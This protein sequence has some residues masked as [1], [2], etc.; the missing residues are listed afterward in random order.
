MMSNEDGN[1]EL[2]GEP[3]H[4]GADTST[5]LL[6][7]IADL[8]RG[9][10]AY[11]T[12][13]P[14]VFGG[15]DIYNLDFRTPQARAGVLAAVLAG[16]V[17]ANRRPAV[18]EFVVVAPPGSNAEDWGAQAKRDMVDTFRLLAQRDLEPREEAWLRDHLRTIVAQ[19]RRSRSVLDLISAQPERAAIIVTDAASY[20]D[21]NIDPYVG[22]GASTPLLPEDV[23]APQLH[24]LGTAAVRIARERKLYVALDAN[25]LSPRR[26]AL[27]KLLCS[28]DGCGV[29]GSSREEDPETIL[30]G[31]VQEWDAWVHAGRLG[32]ALR[33]IEQLPSK[34]DGNKPYLRIQM[35][36]RA[37]HFPQALQA[38]RE[39]LA[40]G[41]KLDASMRVK[42]ARIAQD[43]NA[44]R[45]AS[46]ILAPAVG[47][48]ENREDLESALATAQQAG[49]ADLE[50]RM[51][52]RLAAM[53][54]GSPGLRQRRR[55]ALFTGRDYAAIA[56][57]AAEE[58]GGQGRV[59]FYSRLAK[60]LSG[61]DV[62]DYHALLASA[63]DDIAQIDA[64]RIACVSDALARSLVFHAF[65]LAMPI[66]K[67]PAEARRGERLLLDVLE[68]LLLL[69]DQRGALPV[70]LD[71]V[72]AALLSLIERL[73]AEP[74]N[75][76]LRI[77]LARLFQ[78]SVAGMMGLALIASLVL[79]LASRPIRL[80][81]WHA[82][83]EAD[84]KWLLERKQFLNA[85]FDWLKSEEPV[86]IG[87]A[88]IPEHLM[89]EPADEVVS[90]VAKYLT[91][92]PVESEED[93]TALQLWLTL[94]ASMTAHS[95]DTDFDLRLMRLLAGK[96]ASAGHAQLARDLAEQT[97]L[98]STATPRRRRLGW[99][100][101]ADV[102]HRCHD[103][104]EGLLALACTLAAD[105]AADEEQVWQEVTAVAR[106]LRDSGLH[107]QARSA[108]GKARQLLQRMGLSDLNSHR[109]DTLELQIRQT[110]IRIQGSDKAELE[111]LLAD[112]VRNGKAVLEHG[113]MTE[114]AA[115]MLGQVLLWARTKGAAITP[116]AELVLAELCKGA[117][118]SLVSL[119]RTMSTPEPSAD[120]LLA[121][122]KTSGFARYS[123]DVGYDMRN[124]AIAAS[125]ALS[126]AKYI[127]VGVNTS[128]ALETLADRGVAVPGWDEAAEPPPAPK[129]IDEP[130][131]IACS[132]SREGLSVVQ[133]GFD[134]LG[135]LVRVSAVDGRLSVPVRE[136]DDVMHEERLI[137]WAKKFPYAY[138]VDE[139][140]TNLFYTTTA[141]LRLSSLPEGPVVIVA[142]A[143]LQTF[144][145]NL[146]YV[147]EE[148]AGR[149]R[150]MAAAPSLA[151]LKAARAKGMIGDGRICAWISTTVDGA[152]TQ[153]LP[154]IAERLEP[155]FDQYRVIVDN[156]S[157]LP[158]EFAGA[159]MA[160]IA[161]HG[162][163]HPEGRF[164][165]VVSDE[166][167]LR[168]SAGELANALRNVGIV[169]LFVCS[170]GRADKHPWANTTLGL[171][172]Q[173]L[174][175]GCAA[176]IASPW[177]L[178]SRVPSHWL[179]EFLDQWS[180]GKNLIDANFAAN[181][182]VDQ[183]FSR[184]PARGLAMTIFGNPGLRRT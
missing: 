39:E 55:R 46:E 158:P 131:E 87:R 19:D 178:D 93:I 90:A 139:T 84:P 133:A 13:N 147:G 118:G 75:H 38:I 1:A 72:Q 82:P 98:N 83:G 62:P 137:R 175:R 94:A 124:L 33:D 173:I 23:W 128:F 166:G 25:Q 60:Y 27:S 48:L 151:W 106:F 61:P 5:A 108:I 168:V 142:D 80:E 111:A 76:E 121:L 126:S 165:R 30:A 114:P 130:A 74:S 63:G 184:D 99:F 112:V 66:P 180:R 145:P 56:A 21:D 164:F 40:S 105:D 49:P 29:M 64:Y 16:L 161:A 95:S 73:A 36:H 127:E 120:D 15:A 12:K 107:D 132:I 140:T 8:A 110:G 81:K 170:G 34:L 9:L 129:R 182:V 41:R 67:N 37:G 24:A 42:L 89:T 159:S 150:P 125:R 44:S 86:V 58:P 144:P 104:L 91:H 162:G 31:R 32:Q 20:R 52:E 176:V 122:I 181:Q 103:H 65:E 101:M 155:T 123:D 71:R 146:F 149:T 113:D 7:E 6:R 152:G 136:P 153:T 141:D 102:Y 92:A 115:A 14:Q 18:R 57:M 171:A 51:A 163:I 2:A 11:I 50:Q 88:K 53:F 69:A 96:L 109:L 43:A 169:I 143:G 97:L 135:R 177:P 179:P 172:K 28:I 4:T 17:D 54:P 77:R 174:D 26:E 78:P 47:E 148:F 10:Q 3:S 117:K 85:A 35:L 167:N 100:A 70:P 160:V 79:N 183:R 157:T 119:I 59:E 116:D 45:L 134:A 22:P 138:G 156:G 154:M 68:A